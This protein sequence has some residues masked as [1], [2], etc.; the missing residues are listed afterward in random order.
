[1]SH[2][3]QSKFER[4]WDAR[5]GVRSKRRRLL[6]DEDDLG[7]QREYFPRNLVAACQHPA[8][9]ALGPEAIQSLLVQRL[10]QYLDF[11]EV[12]ELEVIN[13]VLLELA[14]KRE[15]LNLP[16]DMRF[17]AHYIYVDEGYHGLVSA[18]LKRQVEEKTGITPIPVGSHHFLRRLNQIE[19]TVLSESR[20]LVRLG[21]A[22]ISETLIS[23]TLSE[24]PDDKWLVK[25]VSEAMRD[26]AED[27][28]RHHIYF[29]KLLDVMWPQL[30]P[31]QRLTIGPLLPE[32]IRAF[33]D[34]D[35]PATEAMLQGSGLDSKEISAV[36]EE[37]YPETVA[38]DTTR[39]AAR[40]VARATLR[41]IVRNGILE[42]PQTLEAFQVAGLAD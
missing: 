18:D 20:S 10:Y 5:S 16:E 30:T 24:I 38:T 7:A 33:L 19:A 40:K 32:F 23:A 34:P 21:F 31:N 15:G 28:G 3:Y 35:R 25:A 29:A 6:T 11:T 26:H 4:R 14:H 1:V 12:L 8:V 9:I 41:H 17:D 36:V 13:P 22:I 42:D 39:E 27:E 2:Q 37:Y